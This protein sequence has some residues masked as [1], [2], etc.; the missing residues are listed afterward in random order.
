MEKF[1]NEA[2]QERCRQ[3]INSNVSRHCRKVVDSYCLKHVCQYMTNIYCSVDEFADMMHECGFM[4][5]EGSKYAFYAIVKPEVL[6]E[7]YK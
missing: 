6:Q 4:N 7:Y 3:W 1:M 2:E 5:L